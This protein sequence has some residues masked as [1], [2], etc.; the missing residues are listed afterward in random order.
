MT[1]LPAGPTSRTI[2]RMITPVLEANPE[3]FYEHFD[4]LVDLLQVG[5]VT[6]EGPPQ[7]LHRA[8][9]DKLKEVA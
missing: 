1:G 8:V 9:V 6:L 7:D 3:L 4:F 2:V 5:A